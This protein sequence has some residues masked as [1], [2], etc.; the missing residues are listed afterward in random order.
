MICFCVNCHSIGTDNEEENFIMRDC[1]LRELD[2]L[3]DPQ[4]IEVNSKSYVIQVRLLFCALDTK[5][6]EKVLCCKSCNTAAVCPCCRVARGSHTTDFKTVKFVNNRLFLPANHYLNTFGQAG[7]CCPNDLFDRVPNVKNYINS[8]V[9]KEKMISVKTMMDALPNEGPNNLT[10]TVNATKKSH[11]DVIKDV[12]SEIKPCD[13]SMPIEDIVKLV[14]EGSN[15]HSRAVYPVPIPEWFHEEIHPITIRDYLYYQYCQ[16][17][18][19]VVY[20]RVTHKAYL[21]SAIRALEAASANNP[22]FVDVDGLQGMTYF[23]RLPYLRIPVFIGP[24][25]FHTFKNIIIAIFRL[26]K[27]DG[28]RNMD[29]ATTLAFC[30]L[31]HMHPCITDDNRTDNRTDKKKKKAKLPW[32]PKAEHLNRIDD[33]ME[34]CLMLPANYGDKINL[35]RLFLHLGMMQSVH[36]IKFGSTLMELIVYLLSI[37]QVGKTIILFL[38]LVSCYVISFQFVDI[39]NCLYDIRQTLSNPIYALQE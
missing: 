27:G 23:V 7:C 13:G 9:Y 3:K 21:D 6:F 31:W 36:M 17:H 22:G 1:F 39:L 26:M 4:E 25:N 34:F 33:I 19:P 5:A 10:I 14:V 16:F 30:K 38:W 28:E 2:F 32:E 24:D 20:N 12:R 29:A 18:Q 11:E 15:D 8:Q 35:Q 37:F